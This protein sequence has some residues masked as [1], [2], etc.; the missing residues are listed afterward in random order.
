MKIETPHMFQNQLENRIQKAGE[1]IQDFASD[2][3]LLYSKAYPGRPRSVRDEDLVRRF[4]SGLLIENKEAGAQVEYHRSPRTI[5]PA[6]YE[7]VHYLEM[8]GRPESTNH[9]TDHLN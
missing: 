3:K 1:S 8:I 2:L 6:V 9:T 4:M 7:M 5:D